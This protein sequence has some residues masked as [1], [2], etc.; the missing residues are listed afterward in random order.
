MREAAKLRCRTRRSTGEGERGRRSD[1][2]SGTRPSN[3]R[4]LLRRSGRAAGDDGAGQHKRSGRE[5]VNVTEGERVEDACA[6]SYA[7]ALVGA[8]G[9]FMLP[10]AAVYCL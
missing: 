6:S 2:L 9:H 5:L 3:V 10:A 8:L 1:C 4:Q 7:D